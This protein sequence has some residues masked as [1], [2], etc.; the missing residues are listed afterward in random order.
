MNFWN[1]FLEYET[2]VII[3]SEKI[4]GQ[5]EKVKLLETMAI[6]IKEEDVLENPLEKQDLH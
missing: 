2:D 4:K 3:M 6:S 5:R 1:D